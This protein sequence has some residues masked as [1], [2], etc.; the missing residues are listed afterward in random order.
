LFGGLFAGLLLSEVGE[1]D[2]EALHI[3]DSLER[4]YFLYAFY[5]LLNLFKTLLHRVIL[6]QF[7][8][9]SLFNR[10]DS[11]LAEFWR[12]NYSAGLK[13]ASLPEPQSLGLLAFFYQWSELPFECEQHRVV[14]GKKKRRAT[15]T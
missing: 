3:C 2:F 9:K 7:R 12:E 4:V 11:D 5:E 15:T 13:R 8:Q 10:V 6:R 1:S 14:L